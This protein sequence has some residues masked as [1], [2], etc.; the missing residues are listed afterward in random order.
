[1]DLNKIKKKIKANELERKLKILKTYSVS[2][3]VAQID[4]VKG[5]VVVKTSYLEDNINSMFTSEKL[6]YLNDLL[7]IVANDRFFNKFKIRTIFNDSYLFLDECHAEAFKNLINKL[8]EEKIK[9]L[10][11]EINVLK[12]TN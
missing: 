11:S 2:S 12:C 3:K 7:N 4:T 9:Q 8:I 10:E 6:Y 5:M 1:M